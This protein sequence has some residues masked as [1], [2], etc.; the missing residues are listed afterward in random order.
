MGNGATHK[1]EQF[2]SGWEGV[3]SFYIVV[4]NSYREPYD[5]MRNSRDF[6]AMMFYCEK[7]INAHPDG[8]F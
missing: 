3:R 8:E 2:P 1:N 7:E 6:F 4:Y 5:K